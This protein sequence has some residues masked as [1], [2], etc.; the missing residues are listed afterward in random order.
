MVVVK[1]YKE[2]QLSISHFTSKFGG[3]GGFSYKISLTADF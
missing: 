1:K 3:G 2:T